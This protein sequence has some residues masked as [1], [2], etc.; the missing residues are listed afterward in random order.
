MHFTT[1][2]LVKKLNRNCVRKSLCIMA[3]KRIIVIYMSS[4]KEQQYYKSMCSRK[5]AL[6]LCMFVHSKKHQPYISV[7]IYSRKKHQGF[8]VP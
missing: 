3:K 6:I 7:C 2:S 4:Q 8:R 5:S 1:K